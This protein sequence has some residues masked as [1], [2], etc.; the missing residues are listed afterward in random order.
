M[1][2]AVGGASRGVPSLWEK[3]GI[4]VLHCVVLCLRGSAG[5]RL[6]AQDSDD[7]KGA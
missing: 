6:S 3:A 2:F 4:M 7:G 1:R 5:Q